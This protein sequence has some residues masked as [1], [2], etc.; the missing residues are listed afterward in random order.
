LR[1][2]L[3]HNPS[4]GDEQ[5]D[6]ESLVAAIEREGHEVD[7]RSR[8]DDGWSE[9]L[10]RGP[11]LVVVAGGDGTVTEV[12]KALAGS[13]VPVTLI[14][15]GNANNIADTLGFT[16]GDAARLARGWPGYELGRFD[17]GEVE[18]PWGTERF[19]EGVGAGLFADVLARAER[20]DDDAAADK[21]RRGLELLRET[22]AEADAGRWEPRLDGEHLAGELLGV[23]ALNIR[24]TGPEVR[25]APA[26]DPGDGLLD[27][28]VVAPDDR[29]A[30]RRYVEERLGDRAAE[31]P[32]LE[33]RRGRELVLEIPANGVLRVDDEPWP[34]AS[35]RREAG[36]AVVRAAVQ[37]VRVLAPPGP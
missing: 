16:S 27:V 3:I 18:T 9:G 4:A 10:Q 21:V 7:Y 28:V 20:N 22:L 11:E 33:V 25:L 23:E 36:T 19:V 14:P 37:R 5:H 34:D 35:S 30:L 1:V 12:F 15:R 2:A 24:E 31:A 17:L 8:K 6:A 13:S 26:A 32:P 29:D